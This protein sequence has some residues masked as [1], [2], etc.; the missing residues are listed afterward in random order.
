MMILKKS[1]LWIYR[2]LSFLSLLTV[3]FFIKAI[4]FPSRNGEVFDQL[5]TNAN[6]QQFRTGVFLPK[7]EDGG[8][9]KSF[10]PVSY[11]VRDS[12]IQYEIDLTNNYRDK[13]RINWPNNTEYELVFLES[14]NRNTIKRLGEKSRVKIITCGNNYYQGI[15][16]LAH[17]DFRFTVYKLNYAKEMFAP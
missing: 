7:S 15:S 12:T 16:R 6:T 14:N 5:I 10:L 4:Y 17:G 1:L 2:I 8:I 3:L 11:I 13:Y 9:L